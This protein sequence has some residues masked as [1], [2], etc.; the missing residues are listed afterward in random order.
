MQM[1][2]T[3]EQRQA[4]RRKIVRQVE[5]GMTATEARRLCPIPMHRTTVYRL[6]QQCRAAR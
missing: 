1:P 5:H 6:R 2:V 4:V 3:P